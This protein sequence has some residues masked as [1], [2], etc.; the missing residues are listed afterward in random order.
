MLPSQFLTTV[1]ANFVSPPQEYE[2]TLLKHDIPKTSR[3]T[4]NIRLMLEKHVGKKVGFQTRYRRNESTFV[5][6]KE[7]CGDYI[8][9]TMNYWSVL[10]EKLIEIFGAQLR[11]TVTKTLQKF[12][13]PS[14]VEEL[15]SHPD[16]HP[17]LLALLNCLSGRSAESESTSESIYL[18][19]ILE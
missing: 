5:Y 7:K 4:H 2:K 13:R 9:A 19:D 8:E 14:S 16:S 17:L 18:A 15:T 6:N 11:D 3:K 12:T 10:D 1:T